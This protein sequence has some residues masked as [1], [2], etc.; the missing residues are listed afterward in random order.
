V[1]S[2]P[3]PDEVEIE[4]DVVTEASARAMH[5]LLDAPG[6]PPAEGDPLPPLWHWMAF[7]PRLAHSEMGKDGHP[8][9]MGPFHSEE[10]PRRMFA[11]ARLSFLGVARV[12]QTLTRQTWLKSVERKSGRSGESLFA[13][14]AIEVTGDS[15]PLILEEQE[16]V[17][18][19]AAKV[20]ASAAPVA[21]PNDE[22]WPWRLTLPT[23]P[24]T[25]FRYSALTYNAH[26]IHYDRDYATHEEGYPG[27]VVQGPLQAIG[28]AEVARRHAPDRQAGTYSFRATRPA[29][30]GPALGLCGRPDDHGVTLAVLDSS[31]S[32]TVSARITW[33]REPNKE[34]SRQ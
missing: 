2:I 27:L 20:P 5:G 13:T 28:L 18:R 26:R 1:T 3:V 32:V 31:S 34:G 10:F 22:A 16:I 14:V 30:D 17:F 12:G 25:L 6:G 7:L 11:G 33:K 23:D 24:V 29:F 15:A 21:T 9:H 4:K 19:P 8:R